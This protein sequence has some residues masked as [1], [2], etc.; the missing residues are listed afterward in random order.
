[1]RHDPSSFPA[2][3]L[4][5]GRGDIFYANAPAIEQTGRATG[6]ALA[7]FG[8]LEALLTRLYPAGQSRG[9]VN[10]ERAFRLARRRGRLCLRLALPFRG[11]GPRNWEVRIEPRESEPEETFQLS[12]QPSG[13]ESLMSN[14]NKGV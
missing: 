10:L 9:A 12:F 2:V 14:P 11:L 13:A 1:M 8:T 6:S 4:C 7:S 5:R 3:L